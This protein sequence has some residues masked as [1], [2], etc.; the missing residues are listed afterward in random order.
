M[1]SCPFPV[2]QMEKLRSRGG[3]SWDLGLL[4][5]TLTSP[6]GSQ[7]GFCLNQLNGWVET[8]QQRQSWGG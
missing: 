8:I 4:P 1:G 2:V 7:V 6:P 5:A 3:W